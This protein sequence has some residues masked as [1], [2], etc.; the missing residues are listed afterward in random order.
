MPELEL[1]NYPIPFPL[2]PQSIACDAVSARFT[3]HNVAIVQELKEALVITIVASLDIII[4]KGETLGT[5]IGVRWAGM[6]VRNHDAGMEIVILWQVGGLPLSKGPGHF[7]HKETSDPLELQLGPSVIHGSDV[8]DEVEG[9][10]R[11][12]NGEDDGGD[13][14][15]DEH[16][17]PLAVLPKN[18]GE[19]FSRVIHG[20][21]PLYGEM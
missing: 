16:A 12:D 4:L 17:P 13:H 7:L 6:G 10:G 8:I 11:H 3:P 1:N 5:G 15:L 18:P 20:G 2:E 14:Q 9:N 19:A 21:K